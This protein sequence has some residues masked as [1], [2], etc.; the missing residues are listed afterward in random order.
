MS[1]PT[2]VEI[3]QKKVAHLLSTMVDEHLMVILTF[4]IRNVRKLQP[5]I[6]NEDCG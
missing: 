1:F 6:T 2:L 5:K 4:L 3:F